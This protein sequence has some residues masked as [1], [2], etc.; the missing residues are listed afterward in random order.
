MLS[1]L[2]HIP[3]RI[4]LGN[5]SLP[6][7]GFGLFLVVWAVVAAVLLARTAAVHEIGRAHV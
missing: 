3:T 2:F 7:A 4:A 5:G 1:T 6:L